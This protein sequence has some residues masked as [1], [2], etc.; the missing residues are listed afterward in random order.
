MLLLALNLEENDIYLAIVKNIYIF[1]EDRLVETRRLER[2][3]FRATF[4]RINF[5]AIL[6]PLLH[7]NV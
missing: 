6:G 5:R 1:G 4:Q 2:G 7:R 3:Y